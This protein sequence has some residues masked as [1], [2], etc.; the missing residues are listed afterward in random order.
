MIRQPGPTGRLRR[1]RTRPTSSPRPTSGSAIRSTRRPNSLLAVRITTL[2]LAGSLTNGGRCGNRR[3][4]SFPSAISAAGNLRFTPAAN[5]SGTG[6]ASFTFQVQDDGGTAD[7]G[8]DLDP[9]PNTLTIDVTEV[10]DPPAGTDRTVTTLEDVPYV[11]TVADFGFS[12]PTDTPPDSLLAVD[13]VAADG[14]VAN[15]WRTCRH[16]WPVHFRQR[17]Q[18]GQFPLYSRG[19]RIR[20]WL[21]QLH[22]PGSG[23]R[24]HVGRRRRSRSHGQ[25]AHDRCD[26]SQ[27]RSHWRRTRPSRRWRIR[28]I[29]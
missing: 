21:R 5:A 7:G 14:G 10:N 25:H 2:P 12:D 26:A 22:V 13:Y 18:R 8:V 6:Y 27:R 19:R 28:P 9:T 16:G 29:P 15:Q 24:R 11:L 17:H 1:W 3:A 20:R 23:R 4:S